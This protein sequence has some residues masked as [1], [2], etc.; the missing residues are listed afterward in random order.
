[1]VLNNVPDEVAMGTPLET[2]MQNVSAT[3]TYEEGVTATV[4]ADQLYFV[5]AP[6]MSTEC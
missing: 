2:A 6:D 3:V 5:S 4:P 1:M